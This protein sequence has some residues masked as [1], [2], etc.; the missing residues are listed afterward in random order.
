MIKHKQ[1]FSQIRSHVADRDVIR[2]D[3]WAGLTV[4]MLLVPQSMAYAQLAGLPARYGLYAALV[5]T[6]I[7]GLFGSCHQL[8]PGPVALTSL[9]VFTVLSEANLAPRFSE[10]Y[11]QLAFLLAF[12]AGIIR[13]LIGAFRLTQVVNFISHPVVIGFTNAGALIIALSQ[14][15]NLL[16]L[17]IHRSGSFLMEIQHMAANLGQV[18]PLTMLLGLGALGAMVLLRRLRPAWPGVLIVMIAAITLSWMIGLES[19]WHGQVAGA[20][21][22]GLPHLTL[23]PFRW[24]YIQTLLPGSLMLAIIG[25]IEVLAVSKMMAV[26]TRTRLN[27][28]REII[29]QG[30][31]NVAGSFTSSYPVSGSFSRSAL[32][33]YAGAQTRFSSVATA[34][35]VGVTLLFFTPLLYHLPQSVLSATIIASV[36]GLVDFRM[37]K[38]VGQASIQDGLAAWVTFAAVLILA[39]RLVEAITIGAILSIGIFLYRSMRPYTAL[40]ARHP[41]GT[42]RDAGH[43]HLTADDEVLLVRFE[44]QLYFANIAYFEETILKVL[45]EHPKARAILI[46][47]DGINKIDASGVEKLWSLA[48]EF[49]KNNLILGFAELK[50]KVMEVLE[51]TGLVGSI[52][53]EH[54][55]R[56]TAAGFEQ[57]KKASRLPAI[58]AWTDKAAVKE[59]ALDWCI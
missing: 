6:L 55:F 54:F 14:I 27:L 22:R 43:H 58:A 56:T 29:A 47:G 48:Q 26:K 49:Q 35:A 4:A 3:L 41:D 20:I 40:L 11:V 52:G 10:S 25:S 17:P 19:H 30:L 59:L 16:G 5:P 1:I 53:P 32:N 36:I 18:Q 37:M 57:L 7:G 38:R 13:L 28:R 45:S 15:P 34:L 21:P 51:R 33:W 23:P 42:F 44:G 12:L 39:P 50:W 24:D 8:S 31:A 46:V 2:K 9:L